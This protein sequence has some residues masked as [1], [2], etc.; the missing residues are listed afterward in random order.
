LGLLEHMSG[1]VGNKKRAPNSSI[2]FWPNAT[3]SCKH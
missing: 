2:R 1:W 3:I